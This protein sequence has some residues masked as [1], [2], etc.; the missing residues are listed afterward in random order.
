MSMPA[1][2]PSPASE[3]PT[4]ARILEAAATLF[5]DGSY[6][7]VTVDNV[8]EAAQVTKGAV[9]HHF[10][11]KEQLY[12][13]MLL[14]DLERKRRRNQEVV[15][16]GGDCRARLRALTAAFFALP[17]TER[18]LIHLVRRDA[19]IFDAR[20]RGRLVRAYQAALPDPISAIIRD[21]VRDGELIPCDPRLMAWQFIALV[22]VVLT[23]Y[24]DQRFACDED[25]L[26]YV[27]SVF[28]RGC[29]RI[30]PGGEP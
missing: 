5:V 12:I 2:K 13:H 25:K 26:N 22:E 3:S 29:E 27:M 8:A 18:K 14:A 21:G 17:E 24:A 7:D 28:F 15:E 20:T 9:Y 30:R 10:A 11:S 23:P 16:A 6:A 1:A 4:A 19:N